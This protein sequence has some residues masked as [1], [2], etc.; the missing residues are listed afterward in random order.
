MKLKHYLI[1]CAPLLVQLLAHLKG[2]SSYHDLVAFEHVKELLLNEGAVVLA[3]LMRSPK[4]DT[5]ME[6]V[7]EANDDLRRRQGTYVP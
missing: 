4:D 7:I 1:L 3:M 2:A 5:H 6:A